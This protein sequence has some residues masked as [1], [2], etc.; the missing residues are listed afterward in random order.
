MQFSQ[1]GIGSYF[2]SN[3]YTFKKTSD[4]SAFSV[5]NNVMN[6]ERRFNAEDDCSERENYF[7][8]I[9]VIARDELEFR[10]ANIK[11]IIKGKIVDTDDY[12]NSSYIW[13]PKFKKDEK[14]PKLEVLQDIHTF[15][16]Y[17]FYGL[18]KPSIGEVVAQIPDE[19]FHD[20]YGFEIIGQ[21]E[22]SEDLN[23]YIHYV[24]AGY[25][26]AVTRLYKKII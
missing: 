21:P 6:D 2:Y 23:K 7:E 5:S 15:H 18:F 20:V 16:S 4:K 17:G 22:S 10:C 3:G 1:L 13:D 12:I 24:N 19:L 8:A 9:P 26:V 25:H 14:L 11:A